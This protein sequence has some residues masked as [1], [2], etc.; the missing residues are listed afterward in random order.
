MLAK[1]N[2]ILNEVVAAAEK[3]SQLLDELRKNIRD[4]EVTF[5]PYENAARELQVTCKY[6]HLTWSDRLIRLNREL[7]SFLQWVKGRSKA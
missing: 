4:V 3:L 2:N 5:F 6:A 1:Q 7:N